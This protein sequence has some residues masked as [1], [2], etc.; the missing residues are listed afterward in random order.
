MTLL[1]CFIQRFFG[2]HHRELGRV[3]TINKRTYQ[4]CFDCGRKVDYSWE[5]MRSLGTNVAADR[6]ASLESESRLN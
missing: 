1:T 6:L 4:V 3:F 2:C 5:R